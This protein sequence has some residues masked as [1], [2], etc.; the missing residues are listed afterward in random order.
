MSTATM[1][2]LSEHIRDDPISGESSNVKIMLDHDLDDYLSEYRLQAPAEP[3]TH[4]EGN[5]FTMF[6][7]NQFETS[8]L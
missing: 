7:I 8:K 1:P 4:Y 2:Q 6:A 3:V 5:K